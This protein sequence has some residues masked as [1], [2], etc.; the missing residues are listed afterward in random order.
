[1]VVVSRPSSG[2]GG[3]LLAVHAHPDDE[4]INTGGLIA[5]AVD[6]GWA[7]TVVTCTG[8]ERGEVFDAGMDPA[9]VGPRIAEVRRAELA[10]ALAELGADAPVWLGYRDSGMRGDAANDDPRSFWRAPFDEA[11][12]RLVAVIRSVRPRLVVSYD[13][14]GVYGHP[15]HVQAH[16][17][18]TCAVDAAA[19]PR[20]FGEAGPPWQASALDWV[21]L[22]RSAV[23]A[24]NRLLGQRGM[25]SPFGEET[26]PQALTVGT[27]DDEIDTEL[28]VTPWLDR[29]RR[30]LTAHR[31]QLAPDSLFL[32]MPDDMTGLVF[33]CERFVRARGRVVDRSDPLVGL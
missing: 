1:M 25:P 8:G 15:D 29:K 26:D 2:D 20:L 32:D 28:D 31:S 30:A 14:F 33:G 6:A 12:G 27:P 19:V 5:R 11:V 4:T 9:E 21:T 10:A 13:P 22:S 23:A 17:V 24:V 7:A 18:A 3:R 16:R